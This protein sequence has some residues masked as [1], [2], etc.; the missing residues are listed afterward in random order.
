MCD[1]AIVGAGPAGLMA[2]VQAVRSGLSAIVI[3]RSR[4]GGS[5]WHARWMENVPGFPEGI[6]GADLARRIVAHAERFGVRIERAEATGLECSRDH[7]VVRAGDRSWTARSVL[8][9]TGARPA[10]LDVPG[11]R[12]LLGRRVFHHAD[13]APP[14]L[15]GG[16]W[17][18][19]GG[20][21]VAF[22]QA[23][24]LE[25]AARS[26]RI[27]VRGEAPRPV[28][29][30]L[31][32]AARRGIAVSTGW[33]VVRLAECRG[34]VA[35]EGIGPGGAQTLAADGVLAC[36]GKRPEVT[37]LGSDIVDG[38][39]GAGE[40]QGAEQP[41]GAVVVRCDE[42]GRTARAGLFVAGDVRRGF[43]RQVSIASA[44][45]IAVAMEAARAYR[46]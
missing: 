3:E 6:A 17:C 35:I 23:L 5:V 21:D 1:L 44:D 37:L 41:A 27:L 11:E 36:A 8:V 43:M 39:P 29:R 31:D 4:A 22:D 15:L 14:D 9:A 13:E 16:D 7:W 46:A 10:A 38:G 2:A 25:S 33:R 18:V 24:A 34:R 42:I 20:G 12:D 40:A 45:G 28:A 30:L 19:I 26:V 32:E